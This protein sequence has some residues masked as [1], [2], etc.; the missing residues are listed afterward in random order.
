VKEFERATFSISP[1]SQA[2]GVDIIRNLPKGHNLID[3]LAAVIADAS[4]PIDDLQAYL[5]R[6]GR[7]DIICESAPGLAA[8]G[9]GAIAIYR[10]HADRREW[11]E[12]SPLEF[13]DSQYWQSGVSQT[14]SAPGSAIMLLGAAFRDNGLRYANAREAY[15]A[16][17]GTKDVK[18]AP[19]RSKKKKSA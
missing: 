5:K 14:R 3:G 1:S 17:Y 7:V 19:A 6:V 18:R 2:E 13:S 11:E 10:R 15:R 9:L 12:M 4:R 16:G 8:G